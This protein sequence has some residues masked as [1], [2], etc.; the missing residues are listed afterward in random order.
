MS[1]TSALGQPYALLWSW[2]SRI[3][4]PSLTGE[5]SGERGAPAGRRSPT[6]G[7]YPASHL[8]GT[9]IASINAL[10]YRT[11]DLAGSGRSEIAACR[12]RPGPCRRKMRAFPSSLVRDH[13][14]GF[15]RVQCS[16]ASWRISSKGRSQA[17]TSAAAA[18]AWLT[19]AAPACGPCPE[20]SRT[21]SRQIDRLLAGRSFR[22]QARDL[23]GAADARSC[24]RRAP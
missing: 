20:L 8:D 17:S 21:A 5:R 24:R 16:C 23:S 3:Q 1:V 4:T 15:C 2:M 11:P 6:L 13:P 7:R 12:R 18:L 9:K 22:P 10:V 14:A 19:Q